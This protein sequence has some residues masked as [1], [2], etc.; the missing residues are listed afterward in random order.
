MRRGGLSKG[1]IVG[2]LSLLSIPFVLADISSTL[3]NVFNVFLGVGNLGFLGVSDSRI[4]VGFTRIL[5]WIMIFTIFF[6][7]TSTY[8]YKSKG[9]GQLGFLSKNQGMIVAFVVATIAA[10]YLPAEVLLATGAGWATVIALGLVGAPIIGVALALFMW[11][12]AGDEDRGTYFIKLILVCILFWV[13]TV[14][15]YHVGAM[16]G[17]GTI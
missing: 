2:I 7:V 5:I 14:M 8:G 11:P 17:L 10:V 15:R 4:I 13:L 9:K 1:T 12:K 6:A 16:G 3:S